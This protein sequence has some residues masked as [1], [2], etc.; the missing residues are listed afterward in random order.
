MLLAW[1]VALVFLLALGYSLEIV[2]DAL[3]CYWERKGNCD[4][5]VAKKVNFFT[6]WLQRFDSKGDT[7][8][9]GFSGA[10]DTSADLSSLELLLEEAHITHKLQTLIHNQ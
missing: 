6:F 3:I 9:Y 2:T 8:G 1:T 5:L 7:M 4:V 10:T